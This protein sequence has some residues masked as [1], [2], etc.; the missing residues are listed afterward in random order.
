MTDGLYGLNAVIWGHS[1]KGK[2]LS[3]DTPVP[4]PQGWS[5]LGD[6]QVGD[7]LF[8]EQ[9]E[10]TKVVALG[11]VW[12][13]RPC[14]RIQVKGD[15]LVADVGHVWKARGAYGDNRGV[16]TLVETGDLRTSSGRYRSLPWSPEISLPNQ[17]LL[18][19]PYILGVWLG[20]GAVFDC[21]ISGVNQ[22]KME[23]L[24]RC[25]D[26]WGSGNIS[27]LSDGRYRLYLPGLRAVLDE[28]GARV[29]KSDDIFFKAVPSNYLR[30]GTEQRRELLAGLMDTDGEFIPYHAQYSFTNTNREIAEAVMEL[31]CSLGIRSQIRGP[32]P[33]WAVMPDG[34]RVQGKDHYETPL[35]GVVKGHNI[36]YRTEWQEQTPE[37]RHKQYNH[38]QIEMI[39]DIASVPVRCIQVDDP[40]GMFLVGRTMIPTHNSHL[41]DTTPGPR[42]VLDAEAG[43]RFTPSKKV[44]W[45]PADPPPAP[46]ST[47]T[48]AIVPVHE[49]RDVQ[50]VYQWLNSGKHPF[51]SCVLDSISEIQQRIVD[52]IAGTNQLKQQDWGT[53]LRTSSD[54]V[55]KFRDLVTNK[56]KP[57]DAVIYLGMAKQRNDGVWIPYVQGSLATVLPYYSDVCAYLDIVPL[58]DGTMQR[59]LFIGPLQGYE[60]GE[61]VGGR[62]GSY[63]DIPEGD[64]NTIQK[65]LE[66]IRNGGSTEKHTAR[67]S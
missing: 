62:L 59:R 60:T 12:H 39:E 46:D 67:K 19:H 31:A 18:L 14:R 17:E 10:L 3:L 57:L 49:F 30:A 43:S 15:S 65:M 7:E 21:A 66:M 48:T 23:V 36:T 32:F 4:T 33:S 37:S 56:V 20:D 27:T 25:R 64:N 6:L 61:R 8:N 13:N 45:N 24:I 52:S 51:R 40:H 50:A 53:L 5:A 54:L 26:L 35:R 9:G 47:W 55:R 38:L 34:T 58:E 1:K 44:I 41:G 22:R 29:K 63:I 42:V 28:I 16:W 11:P 2:A